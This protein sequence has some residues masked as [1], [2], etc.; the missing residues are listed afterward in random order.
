MAHKKQTKGKQMKTSINQIIA[1]SERFS[2]SQVEFQYAPKEV[3][4]KKG[5]SQADKDAIALKW[6]TRLPIKKVSIGTTLGLLGKYEAK[7]NGQRLIEGV[8]DNF[9]AEKASGKSWVGGN[10]FVSDK[11]ADKFYLG[12]EPTK[13]ADDK[14]YL[15]ANGVQLTAEEII[16]I[17]TSADQVKV[18]VGSGRQEVEEAVRWAT[19]LIE[20][21][22]WIK[23]G[24]KTIVID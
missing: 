10:V 8:D 1:L 16:E 24:G 5:R 9:K 6:G 15:D 19:P 2:G 11:D 4:T 12:Y 22:S 18:S 14:I 21:I 17:L 3:A 23:I 13:G 7:V 20:S